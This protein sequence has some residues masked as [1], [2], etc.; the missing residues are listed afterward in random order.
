MII[1]LRRSLKSKVF[2]VIFWIIILG[3]SGALSFFEFFRLRFF[4]KAS[5]K[6]WIMQ[7]N[8]DKVSLPVFN[9]VVADQQERIRLIRAQYGQY[10]DLYFRIMGMSL[11]PQDLAFNAIIRKS[12]LN[13]IVAQMPLRISAESAQ[14]Q[15]SN[16]VLISQELSDLIPF[17]LWDH[18]MGGVNPLLLNS[19]L[20]QIGVLPEE[21]NQELMAGV[22]RNIVQR[23]VEHTVYVPTFELRQKFI[24]NFSNHKFTIA[25]ISGDKILNEVKK[26]AISDERIKEYYDLKNSQEKRYYVPEK[27]ST[28]I[29]AF[30][31]ELYGISITNEDVEKYYQ[32]NKAQFIEQPAQVQVR[33]ILLKIDD[34]SKEQEMKERAV[35][36][37]HELLKNPQEF[38]ARAQAISHDTLSASKGGLLD[39]FSKGKYDKV[40]EKTA[41]LLKEPGTI[42]APIRT[43]QG[44]EILQLVDKKTQTFKPIAQVSNDIKT[45]LRNKK[46]TERFALDARA[47]L[48]NPD[49]TAYDHFIKEKKGKESLQNDIVNAPSTLAKIVFRLKEQESTYYQEGNKGYLVTLTTI[50]PTHLPDFN[51]IKNQVKEDYY[52]EEASKLLIKILNQIKEGT[53]SFSDAKKYG[54]IEK[55]GWLRNSPEYKEDAK[56]K[57]ELQKKGVDLGQIFQ[58]E[59]KGGMVTYQNNNN[60]Y[61]I[62]LEEVAPMDQVLFEEKKKTLRAE[63]QGE[64]NSVAT[65][66]FVASLYRNAKINKNESLI[67]IKT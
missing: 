6:D 60:G 44:Y 13:Q 42:S 34:A 50:N 17:Q 43:A 10:A 41:F 19:Y 22:A 55:T 65:A 38:S 67:R 49:V 15:L 57:A 4:G 2:K 9:R 8:K 52:K 29:I 63:L 56:E 59:N 53:L 66:G 54:T 18:S 14:T 1:T 20:Q 25:V 16:P 26:E 30:E 51:S 32:N 7:I 11:N 45:L 33:R 24:Q 27:R 39:Y 23:L 28:K 37:H 40:F 35:Q 5:S 3:T 61:A 48:N 36:L 62:R 47:L 12:L 58:I 21:F 46:F 64:K 31:P